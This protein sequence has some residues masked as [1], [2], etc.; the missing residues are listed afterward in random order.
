MYAAMETTGGGAKFYFVSYIFLITIL[1]SQ[2]FIGVLL[3]AFG[4]FLETE[5]SAAET[6]VSQRKQG[7]EEKEVNLSLTI[8]RARALREIG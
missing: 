2:L 3:D 1:Y 4:M 7:V 8:S 6:T 5:E